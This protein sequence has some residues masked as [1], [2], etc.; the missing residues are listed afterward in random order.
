MA[1]SL[2]V[3]KRRDNFTIAI[4]YILPLWKSWM[5][6]IREFKADPRVLTS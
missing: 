1:W 6:M 4:S 3:I 2:N 5:G